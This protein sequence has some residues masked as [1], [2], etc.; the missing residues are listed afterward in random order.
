MFTSWSPKSILVFCAHAAVVRWSWPQLLHLSLGG[1]VS[2]SRYQRGAL[3]IPATSLLMF[4]IRLFDFRDVYAKMWNIRPTMQLRLSDSCFLWN[5]N[6][7]TTVQLINISFTFRSKTVFFSHIQTRQQ[8]W[9][10]W[11]S[12]FHRQH[13]KHGKHT[14]DSLV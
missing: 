7:F 2:I 5:T 13:G 6:I 4:V 9:Q 11:K 12:W 14:P 10:T 8:I 3:H 1:V